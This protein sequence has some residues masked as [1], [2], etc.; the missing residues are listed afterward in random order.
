[1]PLITRQEKGEKLTIQEMDGNLTY[2]D[3]KVPYKVYTALLTQSGGDSDA[4][5]IDNGIVVGVTYRITPYGNE[6]GVDFTNIGAPNNNAGTYF[7]ATGITPNS[8]GINTDDSWVLQYNTGAPVVTVLENTI[9]NIT[10]KY[11]SV[12]GYYIENVLFE[13]NKTLV[14]IG[15]LTSNDHTWFAQCYEPQVYINTFSSGVS[16]DSI[17]YNTSIEIRVYN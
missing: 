7:V 6:I 14:L 12:G 17:L 13:N 4:G 9:G 2:L 8:W 10:W 15:S 11:D 3:N 16:S 5:L 1:M